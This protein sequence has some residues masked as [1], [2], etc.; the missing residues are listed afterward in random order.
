MFLNHGLSSSKRKNLLSEEEAY[1]IYTYIFVVSLYISI[2][3]RRIVAKLSALPCE[4]IEK[5]AGEGY[6]WVFVCPIASRGDIPGKGDSGD[7]GKLDFACFPWQN[8]W[9]G[10]ALVPN[11]VFIRKLDYSRNYSPTSHARGKVEDR[12]VLARRKFTL[13][14][15]FETSSLLPSPSIR[16]RRWRELRYFSDETVKLREIIVQSCPPP[17]FSTLALGFFLLALYAYVLTTRLYT[18]TTPCIQRN[19]LRA[20]RQEVITLNIH[21][22]R[23]GEAGVSLIVPLTEIRPSRVISL[24]V[25]FAFDPRPMRFDFHSLRKEE[26]ERKRKAGGRGKEKERIDFSP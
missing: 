24:P 1:R 10:R 23:K 2:S 7:C 11:L 26:R 22:L 18:A 15:C 6:H 8:I 9:H 3:R 21:R 17:P 16:N 12:S 5:G 20:G 4:N 25:S 19:F 13:R 14:C